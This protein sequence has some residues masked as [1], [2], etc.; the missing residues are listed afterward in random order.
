MK[1]MSKFYVCLLTMIAFPIGLVSCSNNN[2]SSSSFIDTSSSNSE[3]T[4]SSSSTS[5]EKLDYDMSNV[6]FEDK[7]VTYDGNEH[8]LEITG[9]LPEGV[10]VSYTN[11][12]LT[13]VGS[14]EAT[15]TF[16][17]DYEHYNEIPN[18]TATLTIT[19]LQQDSEGNYIINGIKYKDNGETMSVVGYTDDINQDA[20]IAHR[21]LEKPVTSIGDGAF[22]G[23]H[24]LTSITIPDSVTDIGEWAFSNCYSLTSITIGDSV[25]SIGYNAFYVCS[26]LTSITI[27]DSV[28]YIGDSAFAHCESLASIKVDDDNKVYDSRNNCNAIIETETNRLIAGCKSTSIPDSVTSIGFY[29]FLG[30]TSLTSITIPDSV[31]IIGDNAFSSC[32]NLTSITISDSVTIISFHAFSYCKSLTDVYYSGTEEQWNNINIREGNEYLVN[33]TIHFNYEN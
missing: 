14:I 15:A 7:T 6:K 20:F 16:L 25:T 29:A 32:Y 28:T 30:C 17:G 24:S 31:T 22:E 5:V 3:D 33:A 11:N 23:C 10:S 21:V 9:T 2:I 27:P 12:K 1:K 18:M 8:T 26:S 4:S 13:E 19:P